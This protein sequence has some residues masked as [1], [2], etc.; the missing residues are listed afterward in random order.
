MH[1]VILGSSGQ[2]GSELQKSFGPS[3][4]VSGLTHDDVDIADSGTTA[5]LLEALHPDVVINTAAFHNVDLCE[6][7]SRAA[8]HVN[9]LAVHN[10]AKICSARGSKFVNV[11]TDYVFDG[12]QNSPYYE[13]DPVKPISVYG[14]SKA[15]GETLV[16]LAAKN[17]IIIRTSG[18]Y[19]PAG[20]HNATGNFVEKMIKLGRQHGQVRVVTDQTTAPTYT[21]DLARAIADLVV[22]DA[23]GTF[24]LTN[25]G[26]VTWYEFARAI[27]NR[28]GM[29]VA[30][31][32]TTSEE[33]GAKASRP[34][35]SVLSNRKC[36]ESGVAI[37]RLWD[38]ALE[39][40]LDVRGAML[41]GKERI[42]S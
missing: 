3:D 11:S 25:S 21:P 37:L 2:L 20:I 13:D 10:L 32:P 23:I 1:V 38:D 6:E 31:H 4:E 17:H 9:A 42:A 7:Q 24:H 15:S 29:D 19:G 34:A 41:E 22:R 8:F 16:R 33:F 35:Y 30:V 5:I 40:Y 28:L 36:T 14:A 12:K 27:F 26:E 39:A 18:L